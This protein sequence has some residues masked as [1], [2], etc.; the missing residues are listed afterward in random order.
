MCPPNW[1]IKHHTTTIV[2]IDPATATYALHASTA[3]ARGVQ[4]PGLNAHLI[5]RMAGDQRVEERRERK[6]FTGPARKDCQEVQQQARCRGEGQRAP[7][8]L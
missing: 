2:T 5:R 7:V 3:D 6:L 8:E 4:A 1:E